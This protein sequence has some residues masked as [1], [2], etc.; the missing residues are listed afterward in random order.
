LC[1]PWLGIDLGL[2]G[3]QQQFI[4]SM[5]NG[6][7]IIFVSGRFVRKFPVNHYHHADPFD[8]RILLGFIVHLYSFGGSHNI[9][10]RFG[11]GI[12]EGLL[13]QKC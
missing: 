9:N 8:I 13:T 2:G 11:G 4:H 12:L 7:T 5:Q 3:P 6:R 1:S 10:Q